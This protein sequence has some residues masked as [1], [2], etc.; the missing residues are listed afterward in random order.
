MEH[1]WLLS[2]ASC[3][4]NNGPLPTGLSVCVNS[5]AMPAH[6]VP[7]AVTQPW[8]PLGNFDPIFDL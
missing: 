1:I 2:N 7:W 8:A 3:L 4:K 6:M 5:G